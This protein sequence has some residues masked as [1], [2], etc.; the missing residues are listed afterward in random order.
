[1]SGGEV[2]S[3]SMMPRAMIHKLKELEE[4]LGAR[5]IKLSNMPEVI[6]AHT[7]FQGGRGSGDMSI[8]DQPRSV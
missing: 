3:E 2:V 6:R 5:C 4:L 7:L 1:M 8:T